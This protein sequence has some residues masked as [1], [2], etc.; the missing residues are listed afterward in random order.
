MAAPAV[1][2]QACG[3]PAAEAALGSERSGWSEFD[4]ASRRLVREA[5]SLA[6]VA[7]GLAGDCG[8]WHWQ[9]RWQHAQGSRDYDGASNNGV[10]LRTTSAIRRERASLQAWHRFN[11]AYAL[12]VEGRWTQLHRDIAS[13]AGVSGYP[14]R[15]SA[16]QAALGAGYTWPE[17]GGMR[18]G[19]EA[20]L[21]AGPAGHV[22]VALPGLDAARLRL[23]ASRSA[24][25]G[26]SLSS[27]DELAVAP[28][29]QWR[30]RL[31]LQQERT[32][33]GRPQPLYRQGAL[34]GA[35]VQPKFEQTSAALSAGMA[36]RF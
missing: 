31:E 9:G 24:R 3:A 23:G 35:A 12:G 11:G 14:E 5:G 6:T 28:G 13:A 7:V 2:A 36:Y 30:L 17:V 20:W 22:D 21:G 10:P 33:A 15:F 34:Y 26:L 25:V 1:A 32:R 18:V 4:A 29:W 8:A 16:W 27:G 19:V